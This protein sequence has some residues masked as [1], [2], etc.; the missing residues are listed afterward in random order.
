MV[1]ITYGKEEEIENPVVLL[2]KTQNYR[3]PTHYLLYLLA[4]IPTIRTF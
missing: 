4:I 3:S 1:V 2:F